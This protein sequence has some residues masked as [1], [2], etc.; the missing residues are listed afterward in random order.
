MSAELATI[1]DCDSAVIPCSKPEGC[2]C[3]RRCLSYTERKWWER[4]P[5]PE[6]PRLRF[7]VKAWRVPNEDS[8]TIGVAVARI[9][10]ADRLAYFG[11]QLW[12]RVKLQERLYR[13][14]EAYLAD[15]NERLGRGSR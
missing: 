13:Q 5:M 11:S 2:E 15:V 8:P 3:A 4:P 6:P 7:K 12:E 9:Y 10:A 14:Q 1:W